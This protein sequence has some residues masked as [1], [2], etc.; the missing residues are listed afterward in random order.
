MGSL[1]EA[2]AGLV[3]RIVAG[4]L[5]IGKEEEHAER[6]RRQQPQRRGQ[7]LV[8]AG[9]G[10]DRAQRRER[11]VGRRGSRSALEPLRGAAD[12]RDHVVA[13]HDLRAGEEGVDGD[14]PR[15]RRSERAEQL[16]PAGALLH[17]VGVARAQGVVEAEDHDVAAG[18][19]GAAGD[20]SGVDGVELQRVHR[21]DV[22]VAA[23]LQRREAGAERRDRSSDHQRNVAWAGGAAPGRALGSLDHASIPLPAWA[24]DAAWMRC[25]HAL[26]RCVDLRARG[27]ARATSPRFLLGTRCQHRYAAARR[28]NGVAGGIA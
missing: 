7:G 8:A 10:V 14:D 2:V 25:L 15:L 1:V 20:E 18:R 22:E 4:E 26:R 9:L 21:R 3:A 13:Q 11:R 16:G 5:G 27:P 28:A 17:D 12:L 23:D 6:G 19:A 24:C